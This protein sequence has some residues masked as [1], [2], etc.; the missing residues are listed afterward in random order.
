MRIAILSCG[1]SLVRY[2]GRD[3]FSL[4]IG[5]NKAVVAHSID[6]WSVGDILTVGR[7]YPAL[8]YAPLIWTHTEEMRKIVG[9]FGWIDGQTYRRCELAPN[10]WSMYSATAALMLAKKLGATVVECFGCDMSGE[11]SWDGQPEPTANRSPERWACERIVFEKTRNVLE[12]AG[13]EVIR[14]GLA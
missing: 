3:G 11:L 8:N 2:P 12:E 9:R 10:R 7:L 1:P 13:I 5:V 4:V 6:W 14:H